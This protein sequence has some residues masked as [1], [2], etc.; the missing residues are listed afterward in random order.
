MALRIA[1]SD[2]S[3]SRAFSSAAHAKLIARASFQNKR[4]TKCF[5]R[6]PQVQ[7]EIG[8]AGNVTIKPS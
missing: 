1:S 5:A 8:M 6:R 7:L 2:F 3:T 4:K